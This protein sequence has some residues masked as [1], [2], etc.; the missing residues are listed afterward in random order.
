[1][2]YARNEDVEIH[3]E[4]EGDGPP[5]LLIHGHTL[6][7]RVWDAITP[8]LR[9][10]GCRLIRPDLRGHGRSTRPER[11][12]HASHHA[13][14]MRAVLDATGSD[15]ASVVGYSLGGGVALEMALTVPERVGSL[16]LLS[17]VLP[18]RPFEDTFFANLREVARVIRSEGVTAAMLGPWMDSPLWTGSLDDPGIRAKVETIVRD[19]PGAEYLATERDHVERDWTVPDR[20]GEIEVPTLVIV[21]ETEMPG[22]R[23]F[24]EEIAAGIPKARLE[25]LS[26]LGH[27]H[28]LQSPD[29]VAGKIVE[30]LSDR[31]ARG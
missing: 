1:M 19:F 28:L 9:Q 20:L 21:G 29:L 5:V 14:D 18:G 15:R 24:A 12:Y 22:F 31:S 7:Q 4:D 11:G 30:H 6:D 27:L 25:V 26:R 13:A 17:P 16:V 2:P 10:C 8:G 3:Y 23:E